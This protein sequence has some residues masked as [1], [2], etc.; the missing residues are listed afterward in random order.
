V[1]AHRSALERPRALDAEFLETWGSFQTILEIVLDRFEARFSAILPVINSLTAKTSPTE[2]DIRTL[3][4]NIP[5]NLVTLGHFFEKLNHHQWV[6]PLAKAGF[7]L[8]PPQPHRS[9]DGKGI[10]FEFWPASRYLVKMAPDPEVQETIASVILA[11]PNT[12]N[13]RVHDDLVEASLVL[14]AEKSAPLVPK[15]KEWLGLPFF[16][17]LPQH[18]GNLAIKLAKEGRT[19]EALDLTAALLEFSENA[20]ES[21]VIPRMFSQSL[22]HHFGSEKRMSF[23]LQ[24]SSCPSLIKDKISSSP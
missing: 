5:N 12:E 17:F 23:S 2:L 16:I 13:P 18:C 9:V 7:F 6:E 20:N 4:Q 10:R 15:F 19:K 22:F 21:R 11:L 8:N 24:R 3:R 1:R 14:P